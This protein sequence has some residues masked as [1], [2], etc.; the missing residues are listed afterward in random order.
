MNLKYFTERLAT[1]RDVFESL[2]RNVS[3]EQ[4]K[5]RPA[6]EKW[7][8][9]EVVNHL[10]DEER[11]DF[12]QR[13]ELVLSVPG[14]PFPKIDPRGWVTSRGYYE[15]KLESSLNSFL[16]ERE[17]SLNW[18][19][20]LESPNWE[21]RNEGPNGILTGGDLMAS[22]LAHDYLHIRQLTRLHWQYLG[23]IAHPYST[24]YAGPWKES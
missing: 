4:A 8:I 24:A 9:L 12:R 23:E 3:P 17:V 13:L 16:A 22:W 19:A 5:W 18:L 7:S 20:R 14:Q 10:Y 6:P 15:R 2:V 1:N 21:N 11:E